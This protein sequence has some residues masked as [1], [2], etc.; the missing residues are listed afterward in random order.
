MGDD[1][2]LPE[3]TVMTPAGVL[4]DVLARE[5]VT[6]SQVVMGT[7]GP[8]CR[9]RGSSQSFGAVSDVLSSS[10]Q[11]LIETCRRR[12][13]LRSRPAVH[14]HTSTSPAGHDAAALS[15]LVTGDARSG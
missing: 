2:E 14:D 9:H 8:N 11:H 1:E 12:R 5:A 15:C 7:P 6:A 13:P 3:V 4:A 10:P